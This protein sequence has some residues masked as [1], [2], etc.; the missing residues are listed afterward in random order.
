MG[1]RKSGDPPPETLARPS[2]HP[3]RPFPLLPWLTLTVASCVTSTTTVGAV[4]T[5]G[6]LLSVAPAERAW[7]VEDE[8]SFLGSVV[9]FTRPEGSHEFFFMVRNPWDQDVGMI[10]HLGRTW[11]RVPHEEDAWL[12]TGTVLEGVQRILGA[13][14]RARMVELDVSQLEAR[15][16]AERARLPGGIGG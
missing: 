7:L 8:E 16:R 6:A 13:G 9:R 12:G 14:E 2:P 3:M 10:D 15:T 11:K 4:E 1:H 5:K